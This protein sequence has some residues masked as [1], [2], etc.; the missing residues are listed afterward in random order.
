MS[1]NIDGMGVLTQA[2]NNELAGIN[3]MVPASYIG[4][5][6]SALNFSIAPSFITSNSGYVSVGEATDVVVGTLT[7]TDVITN[8]GWQHNTTIYDTP[9]WTYTD[10]GIQ[11]DT[12]TV[13]LM[14]TNQPYLPFVQPALT[15]E[16]LQALTDA[17]AK[18]LKEGV[19]IDDDKLKIAAKDKLGHEPTQDELDEVRRQIRDRLITEEREL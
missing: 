1:T 19:T 16:Q 9:A 15:P 14:P 3:H 6:G 8:G 2:V 10:Y 17:Y 5:D 11:P 18:I 12:Q 13:P 7:T 4:K